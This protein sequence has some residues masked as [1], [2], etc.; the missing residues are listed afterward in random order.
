MHECF[1]KCTGWTLGGCSAVLCWE[2]VVLLLRVMF[3]YIRVS[4]DWNDDKES[5]ST[6]L[7]LKEDL[8][9]SCLRKRPTD[10]ITCCWTVSWQWLWR[11]Q[12]LKPYV[13]D[14]E[15]L[16][17]RLPAFSA[18]LH[19]FHGRWKRHCVCPC[20]CVRMS[21]VAFNSRMC[22]CVRAYIDVSFAS[23]QMNMLCTPTQFKSHCISHQ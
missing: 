15:T 13:H 22:V 9:V 7:E 23:L 1:Y 5:R 16:A 10:T 4:A 3:A 14:H 8:M 2:V 12:D 20:A 19:T 11:V 18:A 17:H 21:V 6:F